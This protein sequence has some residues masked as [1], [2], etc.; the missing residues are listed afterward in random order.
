MSD[1]VSFERAREEFLGS[2]LCEI[3]ESDEEYPTNLQAIHAYIGELIV[4][5]DD[6]AGI[7]RD[8]ITADELALLQYV[9]GINDVKE[10]NAD[11]LV[12]GLSE[13]N[14]LFSD[15]QF[16][17]LGDIVRD[18]HNRL[19]FYRNLFEESK[20]ESVL[21]DDAI[22]YI[23]YRLQENTNR[24]GSTGTDY[25]VVQLLLAMKDAYSD[26]PKKTEKIAQLLRSVPDCDG[27]IRRMNKKPTK[28]I[29]SNVIAPKY[30]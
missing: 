3:T 27:I 6:L 26:E 2:V 28:R 9:G 16:A 21:F 14:R 19:K 22:D 13:T 30:L 25:D 29:V 24:A 17:M 20:R 5:N 23:N 1:V 18:P 7:F 15:E 12:I 10:F 4:G 11:Q 8:Q